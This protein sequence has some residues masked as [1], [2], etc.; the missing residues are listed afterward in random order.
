MLF[1]KWEK[2]G[3]K[4]TLGKDLSMKTLPPVEWSFI[5]LCDKV[6]TSNTSSRFLSQSHMLV[7]RS[8][9]ESAVWRPISVGTEERRK[10]VLRVCCYCWLVCFISLPA[11]L[12]DLQIWVSVFF[13]I[14]KTP[15]GY[16]EDTVPLGHLSQLEVHHRTRRWDPDIKKFRLFYKVV[17][18]C[19]SISYL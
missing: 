8:F 10:R 12:Q 16:K 15:P 17:S 4:I 14:L 9:L 5:L 13:S 7:D 1:R 19:I 2:C 3:K 18:I 11:L 6:C